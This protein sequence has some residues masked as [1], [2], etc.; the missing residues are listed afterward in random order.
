MV[1][2]CQGQDLERRHWD[3]ALRPGADGR[4]AVAEDATS[5][6]AHGVRPYA[7]WSQ[8]PSPPSGV[9]APLHRP[10]LRERGRRVVSQGGEVLGPYV[11]AS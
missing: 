4:C 9:A 3:V 10:R 5:R 1:A 2:G 7:V 11:L 6:V 8:C